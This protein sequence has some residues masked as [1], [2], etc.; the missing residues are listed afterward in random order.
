MSET[1][2]EYRLRRIID[3]DNMIIKDLVQWVTIEHNNHKLSALLSEMGY[4]K[5][6]IYGYGH[7]GKLLEE[8][9]HNDV[10]IDCVIDKKFTVDTVFQRKNYTDDINV[11]AI[12]VTSPFYF[13]EI[14]D[15]LRRNGYVGEIR[16]IDE[17]LFQV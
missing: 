2:D 3:S 17:I 14:R 12:I 13:S 16:L 7:L 9:L 6:A 4:K 1:F 15:E 11:D 8:V 5:I 10:Q